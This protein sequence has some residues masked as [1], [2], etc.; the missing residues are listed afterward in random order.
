MSIFSCLIV[1]LG[2]AIGSLGRYAIAEWTA[3][4]SEELPW[5]TLIVNIVGSFIIAFFA[6]MTLSHGRF[7]HRTMSA[8]SLW[9]ASAAASRRLARSACKPS[10]CCE[11]AQ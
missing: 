9:S 4:I 11:A 1:M 3:S 10:I 2:G 7:Q 6:T 5:S 8:C